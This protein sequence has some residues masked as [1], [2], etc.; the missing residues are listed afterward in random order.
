M[1]ESKRINKSSWLPKIR[2]YL[3]QQ[4]ESDFAAGEGPIAHPSVPNQNFVGREGAIASLNTHIN[5]GAKI[6]VIQA[7]GGVGKTTL[8]HEYLNSQGF[9]LVLDLPMAKEKDNIQLVD[10]VIEGWLK[11]DFDE[12]P[13]R[14]FWEILRRLKRQLQTRKI[15][16]LI[17]NLEP[18]LDGQG[19]FIEPHR[20]YVELLRVL[21]DPTVLSVTLITSRVRMCEPDV[22]VDRYLLPGLNEQAWQQFFMN[23]HINID[24]STLNAMHK[25]YAGNAKAMGILCGAILEDFDGDIVAYWRNNSGDLLVKADLENLVTSQF[26]RLQELNSEAYRLLYRLGCYRYQDVPTVPTEGLFCLLWDVPE[27]QRR[28]VIESLR[29]RSLVEFNK[30]EY[31]LH[32]MIREEA[33]AR[34][35]ASEDWEE[36]NRKAAEFWTESVEIVETVQ[37]ALIAVEAYYHYIEIEN[38]EL[39]AEILLKPRDNKLREGE[40]LGI[41]FYRLGLLKQM[42]SAIGKIINYI[43]PSYSLS[44]IYNILGDLYWLTGSIDRAIQS[45]KISKN[46][47]ID[48]NII[49]LNI[50]SYFNIG[51]CKLELGEIEDAISYFESANL[52]AENNSYHRHTVGSWF[53][54][55][56]CYSCLGVPSKA[57]EFTEKVKESEE[58][59]IKLLNSWA[60][61]YSLLFMGLTY[62]NLGEP[63]KS[64]EMFRQAIA[65]AEKTHYTQVK[66]KALSGLAELYREQSDFTTALSHHSES[67]ALLEKI[68]A[69]CDLA[70]AHYQRALTY[71]KMGDAEKSQ[72]P[73][74][75]AIR[76]FNAM[77]A[78]N[79]VE[80]VRKARGKSDEVEF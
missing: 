11:Q 79:Q 60:T 70:E 31:W 46:I 27:G 1:G 77:E 64:F 75:E 32:P 62:K 80:K 40:L 52:L 58:F 30:G 72:T 35:R 56:F 9:D 34:L 59:K 12:E 45:H 43:Q 16:V 54:L 73:F 47:A 37:Q 23:R 3:R 6:I 20:R 76:L 18:A 67:I 38:F 7:T 48:F 5:Q 78:P 68:G 24:I 28:R 33:I 2:D 26:D 53:C 14:E 49:G 39:A 74:Q 19:R 41:S 44:R 4:P 15:G 22:N 13:G 61:G 50:V 69:K 66:A 29:N 25:A 21:A 63:A 51:L 8:A 17:D 65:F 10:S 57:L 71:Q 36:A 42:I 55:A